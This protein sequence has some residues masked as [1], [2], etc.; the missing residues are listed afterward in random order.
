MKFISRGPGYGLFLT[1]TE[2]V[3]AL[4]NKSRAQEAGQQAVVRMRLLEANPEAHVEGQDE[5]QG[6]SNYY[7]GNDPEKW[8]TGVATYARVQYRNVYPGIDMVY[9]GNSA[10]LSTTSWSRPALILA[11]SRLALTVSML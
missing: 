5:L 9:Y 11:A 8:R 4:R 2:A 7:I 1:S 6:K 10:S 3:L